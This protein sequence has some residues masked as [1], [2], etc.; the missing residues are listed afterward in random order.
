MP[1]RPPSFFTRSSRNSFGRSPETGRFRVG[2]EL[3]L[4]HIAQAKDSVSI[5]IIGSLN[6]AAPG[7][8]IGYAR[9][10]EQAGANALELN[11]C[12]IPTDMDRSGSEVEQVYIDLLKAVKS[13]VTIPRRGAERSGKTRPPQRRGRVIY[14]ET[15]ILGN[16]DPYGASQYTM[17]PRR[18]CGSA[19]A[20]YEWPLSDSPST[21]SA[22]IH[23]RAL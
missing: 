13:E 11:I 15:E 21:R 1:A 16:S 6:A 3:Y 23:K 2:P 14:R 10:I 4:D 17:K 7:S 9:Q 8:W 22:R 5:P 19:T 12:N 20:N 18:L